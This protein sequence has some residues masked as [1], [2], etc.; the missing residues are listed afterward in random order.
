MH[1]NKRLW[2]PAAAAMFASL[3]TN[4][5]LAEVTYV[6]DQGH[7]EVFFSWLHAGISTQNGEFTSAVA[8]L[9]LADDMEQSALNVV[10]ETVSLSSGFE[11]LDKVLKSED[12]FDIETYP[13]MTFN[14]SSIKKTGDNTLDVTGDLTIHG[15][16]KEVTL[17][18]EMTHKGPHPLGGAMD[19][20]KGDWIAFTATT[21]I[22]HQEFEVGAFSTGPIT[23]TINTQMKA[24]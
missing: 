5:L 9:D 10:I 2:A 19:Y 1:V 21:E 22:D 8:T 3:L 6:S 12:F 13:E 15:V 7:T 24:E 11:E 14:S 20:Y 23:I 16:T 4:N 17:A 18:A